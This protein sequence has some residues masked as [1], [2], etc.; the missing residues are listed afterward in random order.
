V[1]LT[2]WASSVGSGISFTAVV[3]V[4]VPKPFY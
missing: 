1:N 3:T 4:T 2:T